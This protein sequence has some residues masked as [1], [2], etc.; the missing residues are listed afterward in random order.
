LSRRLPRAALA[1]IAIALVGVIGLVIW[2]GTASRSPANLAVGDCFDVPTAAGRIDDLR[3]RACST[4]HGGEVFHIYV[5][6][7]SGSAYPSD[8]DWEASIYPVC[9]PAFE[10][11]TGTPVG[12]RLDISYLFLVPTADRWTTG[13]RRVTCFISSPDGS[14]LS[15]SYRSSP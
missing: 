4:P 11:Y 8:A 12:D 1:G 13:D 5:T 14:P 6:D 7:A 9:D 15:H 3:T 2:Q 10:T